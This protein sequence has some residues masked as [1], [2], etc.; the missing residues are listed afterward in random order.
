MILKRLFNDLL[1]ETIM[2]ELYFRSIDV[3]VD[4]CVK[5]FEKN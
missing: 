1:F 4:M 5:K 2:K 3:K